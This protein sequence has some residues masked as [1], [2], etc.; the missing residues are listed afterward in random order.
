MGNSVKTWDISALKWKW[1]I[2]YNWF[3]AN[4]DS[5]QMEEWLL[6]SDTGNQ[7]NTR[8]LIEILCELHYI[9]GSVC[10]LWT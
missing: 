10:L 1:K 9:H 3:T 8:F 5:Y 4:V 6:F 2:P 7:A